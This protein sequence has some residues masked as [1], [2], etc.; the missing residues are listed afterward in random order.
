M[1]Y[2]NYFLGNVNNGLNSDYKSI[3][4]EQ[5]AHNEAKQQSIRYHDT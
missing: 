2:S 3:Y 5:C 1:F 4:C